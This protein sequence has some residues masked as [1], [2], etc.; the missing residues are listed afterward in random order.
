MGLRAR[1]TP[2]AETI[3]LDATLRL[4]VPNELTGEPAEVRIEAAL[5]GRS[6][7]EAREV[8]LQVDTREE[9][10][11]TLAGK[12]RTVRVAMG[13]GCQRVVRRGAA[14]YD[15]AVSDGGERLDADG[16][17]V[18]ARPGGRAQAWRPAPQSSVG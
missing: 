13:K 17:G 16:A 15:G 6:A 4:H 3:A 2:G 5:T 14:A 8:R 9:T 12:F 11:G 10:V 1:I 18:G 7:A